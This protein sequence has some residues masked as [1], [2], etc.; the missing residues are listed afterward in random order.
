MRHAEK[1]VMWKMPADH[2]DWQ[3]SLHDAAIALPAGKML[4]YYK[5]PHGRASE[6][7]CATAAKVAG[8]LGLGLVQWPNGDASNTS[9]DWCYAIQKRTQ[10][11]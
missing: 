9:R 7:L 3:N 11:A 10:R 5:G 4:V 6:K 2:A 1:V 8:N